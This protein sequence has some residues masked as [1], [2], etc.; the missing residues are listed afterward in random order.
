MNT[1]VSQLCKHAADP[2]SIPV[3][4]SLGLFVVFLEGFFGG[5]GCW[6][7]VVCVVVCCLYF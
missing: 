2:R 3:N 1:A 6:F 4:K 5:V 7:F